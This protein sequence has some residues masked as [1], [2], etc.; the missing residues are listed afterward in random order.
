MIG[1]PD[2][3]GEVALV[4][5]YTNAGHVVRVGNTVRRPQCPTSAAAH[6]VLEHLSRVG[7]DGAPRFLGIDERGRE[8]LTYIEGE[9]VLAPYPGWA[10]T[11]EAL[12]SVARLLRRYHDAIAAFDPSPHTW[13]NA[14]PEPFQGRL[15]THNDPNL[16]NMIFMGGRAVALIDFDLASLGSAVWDVACAAR[17]WAPLRHESDIPVRLRGRS[18]ERLRQF[19]DAYGLSQ[20]DRQQ[21]AD[22]LPLAHD[23]CY[24]IVRRAIAGGHETFERIW[25]EGGRARAERTREWLVMHAGSIR[26]AVCSPVTAVA[27]SHG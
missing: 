9:A 24:R 13:P 12:V 3:R 20:A 4:G 11:D 5:G 1:L 14:V 21:L 2:D 25:S 16:D 26:T 17:L 19:V 18:L 15:V 6:A 23:W 27:Q 7:F 8:I 10:M 22:A